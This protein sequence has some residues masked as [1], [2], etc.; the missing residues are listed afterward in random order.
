MFY[1]IK[2]HLGI[3]CCLLFAI[4]TVF[5]FTSIKSVLYQ[6][7]NIESS[8]AS[9]QLFTDE[10]FKSEVT[11]NTLILHYTLENPEK[12]NIDNYPITFGN[13]SE[14]SFHEADLKIKENL[15]ALE[16]FDYEM[17]SSGQQ[18]TYDILHDYYQRSLEQ[19]DLIYYSE[20]LSPTTGTQAQLPILMAE[21]T[22]NNEQDILNYLT[23]LAQMDDYYTSI[24][25]FEKEKSKQGLFMAS[26]AAHEVI[27]Q[28]SDFI[29]DPENNFL[30]S[31]FNTRVDSLDGISDTTKNNYKLQNKSILYSHVIPAYKILIKGLSSLED[32]CTNEQGLCYFE[33]GQ[34]YYEYLVKNN[35]GSSKSIFE[36]KKLL[37]TYMKNDLKQLAQIATDNPSILATSDTYSFDLS[38]PNTIL[39]DLKSKITTDFPEPPNADY[40]VKYIDSSLSKHLSPAFYL[41]PPIDN[42]TNNSIYINPDSN[43]S[44][45][46]LY[47]TLAHEGYPGHLYQNIYFN[48]NNS[49]LIRKLLNYGGYTEGWATYVEMYSYQLTNIDSNLSKFL[50]LNNA[51]TLYLYANMDIGIN[52]NGWSLK[53]TSDYLSNYG[54]SD[55]NAVSKVYCAIISEPTNYL[56]YCIGYLEFMELKKTAEKE[57]GSNFQLKDFHEFILDTGPAPFYIIDKYMNTWMKE[58]AKS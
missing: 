55:E 48:A 41:T 39:E 24:I 14:D 7:S 44:K 37:N 40:T 58:L 27:S 34:K 46:D 26:D 57:L 56:K 50:Q 22:F 23:L 29:N 10:L 5:Y 11:S 28:C 43:Y 20:A 16:T 53:D 42:I 6:T 51:I 45:I 30:I 15:K 52:Y 3:I 2:K 9:F 33:N 31:T 19:S 12:Y 18:L 47:T 49:D 25:N 38:D 17:L 13:I 8:Q 35:T 4:A 36:L 54:I 21:Y 1:K 32:S